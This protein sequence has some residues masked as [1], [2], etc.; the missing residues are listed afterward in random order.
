MNIQD[1]VQKIHAKYGT[2]EKANYDIQKVC[3]TYAL[4][5]IEKDRERVKA[6]LSF[7]FE[8]KL[9]KDLPITLD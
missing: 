4:I 9:I 5:Q 6:K 1:E 2:T 8:R 7:E 3:E